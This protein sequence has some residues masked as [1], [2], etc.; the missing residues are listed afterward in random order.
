MRTGEEGS[1]TRQ[2]PRHS[3]R[4]CAARYHSVRRSPPMTRKYDKRQK[5][6]RRKRRLKR[7]KVRSKQ[8]NKQQK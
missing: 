5:K 8:H 4:V 2:R 6:A 3:A 7:L 1:L